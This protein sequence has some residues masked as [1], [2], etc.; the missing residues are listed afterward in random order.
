[1]H[2]ICPETNFLNAGKLNSN[3]ATIPFNEGILQGREMKGPPPARTEIGSPA[4][5]FSWALRAIWESNVAPHPLFE[6]LQ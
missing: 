1:M 6:H 4:C 3:V 5:F 2:V